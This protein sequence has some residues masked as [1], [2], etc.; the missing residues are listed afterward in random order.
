VCAVRTEDDETVLF[1]NYIHPS[2]SP[3]GYEACKIWEAARA[4]SAAPFYFPTAKVNGVKFWDGGLENNN[5]IN[6]LWSEKGNIRPR[7]VISLGTGFSARSNSKSFLPPL[8]KLKKILTNLTKVD[9]R[10]RQFKKTAEDERI[11]YFRFNPP[12]GNDKIDLADYKKLKRLEKYTLD[13]LKSDEVEA[14]IKYCAAILA[15]E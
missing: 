11:P 9:G 1:R 15:Q 7:C 14:E 3:S 6:E 2:A 4:T 8:T 12:M 5:P 13:Y 10:H